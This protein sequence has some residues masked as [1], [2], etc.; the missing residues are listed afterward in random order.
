M[1][2]RANAGRLEMIP[3]IERAVLLPCAFKP[4]TAAYFVVV[5]AT[6][7]ICWQVKEIRPGAAPG[8]AG[9]VEDVKGI[10]IPMGRVIA[11]TLAWLIWSGTA[12]ATELNQWRFAQFD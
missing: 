7:I 3:A 12:G 11:V 8:V 5:L 6:H 2:A 10:T 1:R 9:G 4:P